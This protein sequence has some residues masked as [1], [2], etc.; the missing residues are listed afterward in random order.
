MEFLIC[1][2]VPY[3]EKLVEGLAFNEG[4]QSIRIETQGTENCGQ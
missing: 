4:I 3:L 2:K 1:A